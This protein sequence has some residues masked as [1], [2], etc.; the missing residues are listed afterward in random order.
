[1]SKVWYP[2]HRLY[3]FSMVLKPLYAPPSLIASQCWR[4][5]LMAAHNDIFWIAIFTEQLPWLKWFCQRVV[6]LSVTLVNTAIEHTRG[7]SLWSTWFIIKDS[8]LHL[9]WKS[10]ITHNS[11]LHCLIMLSK[12]SLKDKQRYLF[13]N[14]HLE[15]FFLHD[16]SDVIANSVA[17]LSY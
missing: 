4:Q 3:G 17:M 10:S 7:C 6:S 2:A 11:M 16:V 15:Y 12:W 9:Q 1:M 8:V 13:A 5:P 14:T